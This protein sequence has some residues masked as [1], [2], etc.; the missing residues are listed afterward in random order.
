MYSEISFF[1]LTYKTHL[2][3]WCKEG[4]WIWTLRNIKVY[5]VKKNPWLHIFGWVSVM[6]YCT[7]PVSEFQTHM[8]TRFLIWQPNNVHSWLIKNCEKSY[9]CLYTSIEFTKSAADTNTD[10]DKCDF[11]L[12]YIDIHFSVQCNT[13]MLCLLYLMMIM[14]YIP[15]HICTFKVN[16]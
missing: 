13:S 3:A 7:F 9:E 12:C 15:N 2:L 6:M 11:M 14:Y 5:D 16:K 8:P 1:L 4:F 10:W